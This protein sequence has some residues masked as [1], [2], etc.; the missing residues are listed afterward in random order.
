MCI[1]KDSGNHA[2][3]RSYG[4]GSSVNQELDM[5]D[6]RLGNRPEGF[7]ALVMEHMRGA[8]ASV[9]LCFDW[10]DEDEFGLPAE[11]ILSLPDPRLCLRCLLLFAVIPR[12]EQRGGYIADTS[13]CS[14]HGTEID[15]LRIT[16]GG[17]LH[18][19]MPVLNHQNWNVR[20]MLHGLFNHYAIVDESR[21]LY[22]D[23]INEFADR[24]VYS[25]REEVVEYQ[26]R[27]DA[28]W[29]ASPP[30]S[31]LAV[32]YDGSHSR[33]TL[34]DQANWNCI[35][36][37]LSTN[38]ERLYSVSPRH[39]ERIVDELLQR[40]GFQVH[41]TPASRDGGRD[42]LA[43]NR[44]PLGE[45]LYL[46]ECKRYAKYRPVGVNVVRSLYGVLLQ[47]RATAAVLVTTSTFTRDAVLFASKVQYQM[48]LK[49]FSALQQWIHAVLPGAG[50]PASL[51][52]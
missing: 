49:D 51:T 46:V 13:T 16:S 4:A 7:G 5:K 2:L 40:H 28:D 31:R 6:V 29:E 44:T 50:F 38:P 18:S 47:E 27:F 36:K 1:V 33:I 19:L 11:Q 30:L 17:T 14:R 23:C 52:M 8:K 43:M 12:G 10:A 42:I 37:D 22:R 25:D 45:H 9:D 20:I 3:P 15:L 32:L 24:V 21:L 35:L 39:F 26:K 41:L 34:A 48:A